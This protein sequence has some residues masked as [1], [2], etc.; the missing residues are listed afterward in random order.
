MNRPLNLAH[1]GASGHAPENTL[2]AI[3]K[4]HDLGADGVEIDVQLTADEQVVLLH[5]DTL[6]RTS[7]GFGPAQEVNLTQLQQLDAGS[8]FSKAFFGECIPTLQQ[9][10]D[11]AQ[12]QLYFNIEI[13]S[14][15]TAPRLVAAVVD[16]L[17][18]HRPAG[19][20]V[21]S[22][23]TNT[24]EE[25]TRL[26]PDI[27]SGF[28][29]EEQLIDPTRSIWPILSADFH[30]INRDYVELCHALHKQI[31]VWTVNEQADMERM[32]AMGVDAVITNFPDRMAALCNKGHFGYET[33][34]RCL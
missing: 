30:L 12:N 28:I 18:N 27:P 33:D 13:K 29:F 34:S 10:L 22:F 6:Q 26:A 9:A 31:F 24:L 17:R 2:S 21:T 23:D 1:R 25:L 19:L 20:A 16:I 14:S 15:A 32:I 11:C 8:W 3:K 5:D 7:T 4:A